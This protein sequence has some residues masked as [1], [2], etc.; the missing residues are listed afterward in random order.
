[1]TLLKMLNGLIKPDA[2]SI[3]MRGRVGPLIELGSGFNPILTGRARLWTLAPR[4]RLYI[5][6]S[7]LG[8]TKTH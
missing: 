1:M 4:L 2:G 7:V 8:L 5:H 3:K 6:R